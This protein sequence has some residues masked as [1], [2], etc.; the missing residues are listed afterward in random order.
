MKNFICVVIIVALI[1]IVGYKVYPMVTKGEKAADANTSANRTSVEKANTISEEN[2]KEEKASFSNDDRYKDVISQYKEAY[3]TFDLDNFESE[4]EISSKYNLVNPSLIVH[5]AQYSENGVELTYE[6]YDVDQNGV[7]EL[8]VGASGAAG[9][10]YSFDENNNKAVKI[11]YQ[12]TMERGNLSIYDNGVLLSA[13]SAGAVVHIYE[14]GKISDDGK[15]YELFEAIQ[16]E[17]EMGSDELPT[18][19]DVNTNKELKYKSYDEIAEK[20]LSGAKEV[21]LKDYKKL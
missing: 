4:E 9:A 14:F 6:Y 19:K 13:G 3:E 18:Y 5:V 7:D 10:I 16:E 2:D 20:Y 11:F 12:D 21:E 1:F 8:I 17:Y 15:S